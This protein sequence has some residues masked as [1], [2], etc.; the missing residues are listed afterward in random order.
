MREAEQ[1]KERD[2][3]TCFC[4]SVSGGLRLGTYS[5]FCPRRLW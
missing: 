4:S 1:K 2:H 3:E 5:E